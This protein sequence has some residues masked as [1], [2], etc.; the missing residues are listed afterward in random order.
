MGCQNLADPL[1][2][3]G[4][5]S[6][7][8]DRSSQGVWP[9]FPKLSWGFPG[10]ADALGAGKRRPQ[11]GLLE[12]R[13]FV[14]GGRCRSRRLG[15]VVRGLSLPQHLPG[16]LSWPRGPLSVHSSV[17]ARCD[18]DMQGGPSGKRAGHFWLFCSVAPTPLVWGP[19]LN[20]GFTGN[21]GRPALRQH[22]KKYSPGREDCNS[23]V[24]GYNQMYPW[25]PLLCLSHLC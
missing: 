21:Q 24:L 13:V 11:P 3:E 7:K 17:Q 25:V 22:R 9:L 12:A 14:C 16:G 18:P 2:S 20:A 8:G 19:A 5:W 23:G 1:E 10:E 6:P 15:S 4:G